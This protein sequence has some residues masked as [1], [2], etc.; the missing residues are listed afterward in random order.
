V[1]YDVLPSPTRRDFF[2]TEGRIEI[3]L[4]ASPLQSKHVVMTDSSA[5]AIHGMNHDQG[6]WPEK[7]DSS[8]P[9]AVT[10]LR[11]DVCIFV[12]ISPRQ[13]WLPSTR[14]GKDIWNSYNI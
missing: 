6:A 7:F 3:P 13:S 5:K 1:L 10:M 2:V 4:Q 11:R 14:K 8:D 9:V 12:S